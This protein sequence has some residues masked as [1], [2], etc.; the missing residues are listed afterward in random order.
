MFVRAVGRDDEHREE[1]ERQQC[2]P[3]INFIR[4]DTRQNYHQPDVGEHTRCCRH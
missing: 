4:R 3:P 2:L 1:Q